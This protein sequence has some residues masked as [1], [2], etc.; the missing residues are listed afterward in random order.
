MF[1]LNETTHINVFYA[2]WLQMTLRRAGIYWI[3]LASYRDPLGMTL[4]RTEVL[5]LIFQ[6]HR[7]L[8]TPND[9]GFCQTCVKV[10]QQI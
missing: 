4:Y 1:F 5:A 6:R 3:A 2:V 7:L 9:K 8:G 10:K